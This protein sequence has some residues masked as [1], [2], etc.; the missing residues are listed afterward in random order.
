[1][2]EEDI[3]MIDNHDRTYNAL[4]DDS[5]DEHYS[6]V[7]ANEDSPVDG[8]HHCIQFLKHERLIAN[9]K[10]YNTPINVTYD[11]L[12]TR[13]GSILQNMQSNRVHILHVIETRR[14]II[15]IINEK[16]PSSKIVT[17]SQY[18][19]NAMNTHA[20]EDGEDIHHND[21]NDDDFQMN[22][23]IDGN[24]QTEDE[25]WLTFEKIDEPQHMIERKEIRYESRFSCKIVYEFDMAVV[26]N[27]LNVTVTDLLTLHKPMNMWHANDHRLV[28]F[29]EENAI[30]N[31]SDLLNMQVS[32]KLEKYLEIECMK[33]HDKRHETL[34]VK[35]RDFM[36]NLPKILNS[37]NVYQPLKEHCIAGVQI[38]RNAKL[39]QQYIE[40]FRRCK[41]LESIEA[42]HD[43]VMV[44][45]Y[46]PIQTCVV[47][48][49]KFMDVTHPIHIYRAAY[50]E[51]LYPESQLHEL[52]P[53]WM[54]IN[55]DHHKNKAIDP[56]EYEPTQ[57]SIVSAIT[58]LLRY[59]KKYDIILV[60]SSISIKDVFL[61]KRCRKIPSHHEAIADY[62]ITFLYK[63]L[64]YQFL[65]R[66]P[67]YAP[68][69]NNASTTEDGIMDDDDGGEEFD[70][71]EDRLFIDEIKHLLHT[72]HNNIS[73]DVN[74]SMDPMVTTGSHTNIQYKRL[75]SSIKRKHT[76]QIIRW[77]NVGCGSAFLCEECG[78]HKE[79]TAKHRNFETEFPKD[80]QKALFK[81]YIDCRVPFNGDIVHRD[82][83]CSICLSLLVNPAC[84]G[85][86]DDNN[87][88]C[89]HLFCRGC[90]EQCKYTVENP[91]V[92]IDGNNMGQP[93]QCPLCRRSIVK[94]TPIEDEYILCELRRGIPATIYEQALQE[95]NTRYERQNLV[96]EFKRE[97]EFQLL[98]ENERTYGRNMQQMVD[99]DPQYANMAAGYV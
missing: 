11:D 3:Q 74:D 78:R 76:E 94:V 91:E 44:I 89:S 47:T 23:K 67:K 4:S 85:L 46:N 24:G 61:R 16:S 34:L 70:I 14:P 41:G 6:S 82:R 43:R 32:Q 80:L 77:L 71:R 95:N 87:P 98:E 28:Q 12:C 35:F 17:E 7:N 13:A 59:N 2:D 52:F 90:L 92:R 53:E 64:L 62:R 88:L 18:K 10:H 1:M 60:P 38:A 96:N 26:E 50:D 72:L 33:S 66:Q 81:Y 39:L 29:F 25:D 15:F 75:R 19:K 68:A 48:S 20:N 84:I 65:K 83:M 8:L 57:C 49:T 37:N 86:D 58:T 73:E 9:V 5:D 22:K 79:I 30:Y 21:G 51:K 31:Q 56:K 45:A 40:R 93:A 97:R 54:E 36:D 42:N 69:Y 27:T 55:S 99:R 63:G